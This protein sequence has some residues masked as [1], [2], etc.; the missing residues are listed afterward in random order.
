MPSTG[1]LT[2]S[3]EGSAQ[4]SG[5]TLETV[6]FVDVF[7]TAIG[8]S[9]KA[10]GTQ[11]P[12]RLL[13]AGSVQLEVDMLNPSSVSQAANRF[14]FPVQWEFMEVNIEAGSGGLVPSF[15]RIS[16][17]LKQGVTAKIRATW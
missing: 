4:L 11:F 17:R 6:D 5:S 12:R 2:A 10:V 3:G 13:Y 8:T 7:V 9:V 1:W 14:S 16:W 15:N